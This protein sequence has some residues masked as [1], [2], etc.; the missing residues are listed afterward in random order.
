MKTIIRFFSSLKLAIV[1]LILLVAASILGTL[2][3]QGRE[4]ADYAARYGRLAEP[5]VKLRLTDLFRSVWFLGLMAL[6]GLNIA[7][8]TA[9]RLGAKL[10]RAFRPKVESDPKSL[11]AGKISAR[12]RIDRS[13]AEAK[14]TAIRTLRASRYKV[15][16]AEEPETEGRSGTEG[17]GADARQAGGRIRIHLLGR[18]GTAGIFGADFVHLGL[19]V[20]IAGGLVTA[21]GGFRTDLGLNAGKTLDVP[22][23]GFALRLDKFAT[24]TYADGSVKDWKS[25]LTVV[26][27]GKDVRTVVIEVNHPLVHRGYSFYQ[28]AWGLDWD[29][30]D[31]TFWI[32]RKDAPGTGRTSKIRV[33]EKTAFPEEGTKERRAGQGEGGGKKTA[34]DQKEKE[35]GMEWTVRRFFPDFVIGDDN[36]PGTSSGQ[37]NNPAALIEGWRGRRKVVEGWIFAAYPQV[38][39]LRGEEAADWTIELRDADAPQYSVIQAARDP[40]VPLIWIGCLLV[41]AGLFLAFY[42]PAREIRMTLEETEGPAAGSAGSG[43]KGR[44]RGS[45][46]M[47]ITAGG[48]ASKSQDRFAS[49]FARVTAALKE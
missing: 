42:W 4:A 28:S 48:T 49:E 8:C 32:E 3:P 10:R 27:D 14:E 11:A 26:E 45:G 2:I 36:R 41:M 38:N 21:A 40:G 37:P 39:R 23:A 6:F 30:P 5:M 17:V 12:L 15:R 25:T 18:K 33:G 16:I 22:R 44:K 7:V 29:N 24:E 46:R 9:T 43:G 1:L 20:I 47:E 35:T 13:A 34:A 19:L 31:L